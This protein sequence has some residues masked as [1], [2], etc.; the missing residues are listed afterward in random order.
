MRLADYLIKKIYYSGVGHIFMVTGRGS[1]FLNDA[2]AAHEEIKGICLH[3]EQSAAYAALA[4][5]N[6]SEKFGVC[7]VSSG[8]AG[9]NAITGVLNAWQDGIPCLFISG[10]NKL[11]ETS[12]FT[13]I[14]LRTYG[15]QEADIISIVKP[16]TKYA[17]M[18]QSPDEIVYEIE[19][20]IYNL[21]EGRKGPV[22]IDIPLDI[23]NKRIEPESLKHFISPKSSI[24]KLGKK[25]YEYIKK[26]LLLSKRPVLL[27]GG[28][29]RASDS[30]AELEK[31]LK[32]IPIPLTYSA[33]APDTYGT[34]NYL[35]I[36]SVG[37]M[38]CSRAGNFTIQNSDLILVLGCRLNSMTFGN[39]ASKF[40][41]EAKII[42][43]DIDQIEHSKDAVEIDRLIIA[44][45]KHTLH[46]FNKYL[47]LNAKT[48]WV[49]KCAHWKKTFPNCEP[50]FEKSDKI[51]LYVLAK[52]FSKVLPIDSV[53]LTDSGLIELLLPTNISFKKGQRIIHPISQGSM[54]F[55][56]PGSIGAF[57]SSKKVIIS[58]IGDGSVMMNLQ[59]LESISY[60]KIPVK[61]FIINNNVYSV[62]RKRQT[63]MFRSRTIGVD[64]TNGISC[65]NFKKIA[66]AFEISYSKI[67]N[68][69]NLEQ[70][71][72]SVIKSEG[73]IICEIIGKHD[74]DYIRSSYAKNIKNRIVQRPIED[75]KPYLDRELF[76]SE[77][78]IKPI[79]Q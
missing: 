50:R 34:E 53:F 8:C 21:N 68:S 72:E 11:K 76:L 54:G 31:F 41:R 66:K 30:I 79:D 38:G 78:I 24:P 35:S 37:M 17:V 19:K 2:V 74:Q 62:I 10:Q 45:I 33:S 65:P 77:M 42:V 25:D 67:T 49:N 36:G 55:A 59:E 39:D 61:I 22:W 52:C 27:I 16:I 20:C 69:N 56:L 64:S 13:G 28:G 1:L 29:V 14:P 57:F 75:Q 4:Y 5:S 18:I 26:E 15:Q 70:K 12:R 3:H 23:Q 7:M 6:Y 51:D 48:Q 63:D 44:D 71:I 43:V 40:A 9:T 73:S 47:K 32:K 60:N 46:T 58:V